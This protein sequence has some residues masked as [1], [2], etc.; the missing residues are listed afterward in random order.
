VDGDGDDEVLVG[1]LQYDSGETN[2]GAAFLWEG[3]PNGLGNNNGT[4]HNYDF[5]AQINQAN[6]LF[7]GSVASA[8][9]VNAD[10]FDD[11]II[12]AELYGSAFGQDD[13]GAAFVWYGSGGGL[14]S[15][16]TPANANWSAES[17]QINTLGPAGFGG[18]VAS[19][20]DVN[21][22]GYGDIIIGSKTYSNGSTIKGAVFLWQGSV[23]GL[24]ANG[25]PA[26]ATQKL[27][28]EP[29][30]FD[31]PWF[32]ASVAGAGDVDNDG[33]D[34]VLVGAPQQDTSLTNGGRAYLYRGNANPCTVLCQTT[35]CKFQDFLC[36]ADINCQGACCNYTNCTTAACSP[37]ACPPNACP[38]TCP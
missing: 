20:G 13:E 27:E 11:V 36:T 5:F 21:N 28:G 23:S 30:Q 17:N 19:A 12:G 31:I 18:S 1:A 37:Q 6:A 25:T 7:G 3:G 15:N 14:V 26:N 10:G 35:W 32:G 9:D 8:G 2:E 33:F 29:T 16:G 34:D 24:G 4:E 38:G 22:D